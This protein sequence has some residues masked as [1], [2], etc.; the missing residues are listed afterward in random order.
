MGSEVQRRL[1]QLVA[2]LKTVVGS[3][4]PLLRALLKRMA[5]EGTGPGA[6]AVRAVKKVKRMRRK[7][8]LPDGLAAQ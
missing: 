6:G 2:Y 8:R 4:D 5:D 1:Q 7:G 3:D